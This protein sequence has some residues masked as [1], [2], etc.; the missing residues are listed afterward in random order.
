MVG[1]SLG[2]GTQSAQV[3]VGSVKDDEFR[4]HFRRECK[5]YMENLHRGCSMRV[6]PIVKEMAS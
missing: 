4:N 1:R 3:H 2:R 6:P 5:K